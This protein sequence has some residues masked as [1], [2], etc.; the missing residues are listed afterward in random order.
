V[1]C[2]VKNVEKRELKR[3]ANEVYGLLSVLSFGYFEGSDRKLDLKEGAKVVVR[4]EI[5]QR[6]QYLNI[7]VGE[8]GE[9]GKIA[10]SFV[11]TN[12]NK[13]RKVAR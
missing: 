1:G 5:R 3:F 12:W 9:D 10:W 4:F 11:K 13:S 6:R 2:T 8:V 7:D